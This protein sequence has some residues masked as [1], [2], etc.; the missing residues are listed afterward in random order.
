MLNKKILAAAIAATFT[1]SAFA[2]P[3][4]L[5][6]ADT[7][8]TYA[9][10]TIVDGGVIAADSALDLTFDTGLNLPAATT[11]YVR[12][13]IENA[14]LASTTATDAMLINA[15]NTTAQDTVSLEGGGVI[16]D[17]YLVYSYEGTNTISNDDAFTLTIGSTGLGL[18]VTDVSSPVTLTYK[19]YEADDSL[20]ALNGS[21][22]SEVTTASLGAIK[23][24]TGQDIS[25]SFNA[26]SLT[27]LVSSEFTKFDDPTTTATVDAV[28]EAA[29]GEIA[30]A[31]VTG[32]LV[33]GT[34]AQVAIADV[35]TA[36]SGATLTGDFSFGDWTL[37]TN[38]DCSGA[39]AAI[40]INGDMAGAVAD[41]DADFTSQHLCVDVSGFAEGDVI[42]K[43]GTAYSVSLDDNTG[44]SGSLGKIVYDTTSITVP[45]LTTFSAY[46]QRLYIINN[47]STAASYTTA[48]I[49][50]SGVTATAGTAA[51]GTVPAGGMIAIKASD[52]VTLT[53]KTRTSVTIEIEAEAG[54]VIATDRKSVV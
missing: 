44:V 31:V 53:G 39:G 11:F 54:N 41:A 21:G 18:T 27:A 2:A 1:T 23:F 8:L 29:V 16:G 46:N 38:A 4:D 49:S 30:Y 32:V 37:D 52:I 47:G 42:P 35:Y 48:F 50:E 12:V 3:I 45:Y 7:A 14:V 34:S 9:T 15:A 43:V 22:S 13:E 19:L 51:T 5:G 36:S 10:Q 24:A 25:G 6:D 33:A 20:D 17:D 28:D 26:Q 40:T